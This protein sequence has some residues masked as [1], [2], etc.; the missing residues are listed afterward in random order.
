MIVPPDSPFPYPAHEG[1]SAQRPAVRLLTLHQLALDHHLGGDAGVVGAGL[2]EHVAAAHP[3]EAAEH[4]LEGVVEGVADVK[5]AGDV[6]R[7]DDDRIGLGLDPVRATGPEGAG[8]LPGGGDARLD[9][10]R[11]ESLI[12]HHAG[13]GRARRGARGGREAAFKAKACRFVNAGRA[14]ERPKRSPIRL[15][16]RHPGAC[17][18]RA[19]DP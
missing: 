5:R 18:A 1:L 2:P 19:R 4:V 17:E 9:G 16:H 13:T 11:V 6:R 10:G 15:D 12:H 7:R 3:L 8:R 14:G